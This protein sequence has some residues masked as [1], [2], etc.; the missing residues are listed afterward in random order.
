MR[1]ITLAL[2]LVSSA[3][4]G[5]VTDM[6]NSTGWAIYCWRCNS[7]YD[8][9]CA[10]PFNNITSDLVNCDMRVKEHLPPGTRAQVCRKI[11][12]KVYSDFRTVRDCGWLKSDKE[13][14]ECMRRAGTFSV[15]MKYCSCD[16]DGC[17][18]ARRPTAVSSLLMVAPP[19][20]LLRLFK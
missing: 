15:L 1:H 5:N 7:A 9:N 14:T 13:G 19:L 12:Q 18:G 11:V 20:L 2:P 6:Q 3:F 4:F 17:N 16:K 8:P 10:D